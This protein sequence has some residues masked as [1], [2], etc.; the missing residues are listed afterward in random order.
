VAGMTEFLDGLGALAE[1]LGEMPDLPRGLVHNDVNE[2]NVLVDAR[3]R[4]V[5]LLD[6]D[7]CVDS[8]RL[9]D[10]CSL[11]ATWG[12]D[13]HRLLDVVRAGELVAAYHR[14]RPITAAE[15]EALPDLLA[16]YLGAA[17]A[18]VVGNLWRGNA[19]TAGVTD[20]YS[21]RTFLGLCRDTGWRTRLLSLVDCP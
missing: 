21:A 8:F 18:E 13:A 5:A 11:I 14:H 19:F 1:S 10:V 17:G 12:L 6:F 2:R 16:C 4:F 15:A 20:S 9:Y 3:G 7:D